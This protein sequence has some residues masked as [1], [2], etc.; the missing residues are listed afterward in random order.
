[1][2]AFELLLLAGAIVLLIAFIAIWDSL[3]NGIH[4]PYDD[5]ID[6][7]EGHALHRYERRHW[8]AKRERLPLL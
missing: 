2:F 8:R 5:A 3:H 6:W 7:P 4:P 1:M